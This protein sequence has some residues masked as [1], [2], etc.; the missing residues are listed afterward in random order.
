VICGQKPLLF[1]RVADFCSKA[2]SGGIHRHQGPWEDLRG[3]KAAIADNGNDPLLHGKRPARTRFRLTAA[4]IP[5]Q[6][7]PGPSA[8][9]CGKK[10]KT[11]SI[12]SRIG[13]EAGAETGASRV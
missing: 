4:R 2:R 7:L 13:K 9:T 10:R 11:S 8:V 1:C 6:R 5:L 12:F 3:L